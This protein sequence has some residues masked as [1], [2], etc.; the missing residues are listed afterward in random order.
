LPIANMPQDMP[1]RLYKIE[2]AC[3]M[4]SN[5]QQVNKIKVVTRLRDARKNNRLTKNGLAEQAQQKLLW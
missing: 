4:S 2:S 1:S 5:E 3:F